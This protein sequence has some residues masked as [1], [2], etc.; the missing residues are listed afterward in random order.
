M[1]MTLRWLKSRTRNA[2]TYFH[3]ASN[4]VA[5]QWRPREEAFEE[6]G[7]PEPQKY[8]WKCRSREIDS[9]R[10]HSTALCRRDGG[11]AVSQI[12]GRIA[13]VTLQK[14]LSERTLQQMVDVRARPVKEKCWR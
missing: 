3:V 10:A 5:E 13:E 2:C 9:A 7:V 1:F 6:A 14:Q 12:Q 4:R 11:R 8:G